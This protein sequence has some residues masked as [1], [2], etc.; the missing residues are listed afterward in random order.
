LIGPMAVTLIGFNHYNTTRRKS[1]LR[2]S[3]MI[4]LFQQLNKRETKRNEKVVM[5]TFNSSYSAKP[6]DA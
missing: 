2:D 4:L 1:P 3:E 5:A 6:I